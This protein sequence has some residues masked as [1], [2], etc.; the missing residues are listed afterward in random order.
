MGGI[1]RARIHTTGFCLL[2]AEIAGGRLLLDHSFFLSRMF[3]VIGLRGKRMHIDIAVRAILSAQAA[4]DAPVF[5]DDLKRIAAADGSDR[6]AYHAERVAT[7]AAG[8]CHKKIFKPQP[9]AN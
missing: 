9:F 5:N 4:A 1:V 3:M 8:S 2:G 6:A 7:L